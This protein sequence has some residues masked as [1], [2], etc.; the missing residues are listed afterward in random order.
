MESIKSQMRKFGTVFR[1]R[2]SW[3][4]T[5]KRWL[6]EV[7][8]SGIGAALLILMLDKWFSDP[9]PPLVTVNQYFGGGWWLIYE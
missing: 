5:N 3:L 2:W 1:R 6:F 9:T 7:L 8:F 4:L